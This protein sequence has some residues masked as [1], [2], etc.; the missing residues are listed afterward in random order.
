MKKKYL[1]LEYKKF[2]KIINIKLSR[3]DNIYFKKKFLQKNFKYRYLTTKE[4]D[5]F[6]NSYFLKLKNNNFTK[7]GKL[8]KKTWNK[9]WKENYSEYKKTKNKK[10]LIP[11]FVRS[12]LPIRIN[13]DFILPSSNSFE[14][15]LYTFCLEI[16]LKKYLKHPIKNLYEFGCGS[17]HN[18][19]K[20]KKLYPKLN[21]YGSDWSIW[22][23]KIINEINKNN[24]NYNIKSFKFDMFNPDTTL[25]IQNNSAVLTVGALEQLGKNFKKFIN[26]LIKKKTKIC[27]HFETINEFYNNSTM[28]DRLTL[29]YLKKRNYLE[30]FYTYLLYLEEKKIIK[31]LNKRRVF[32]SQYHEGYSLLVYKIL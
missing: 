11:K 22:S 15:D 6:L 27:L 9:G 17:C 13:G 31:I 12:K 5:L 8:K 21:L 4:F 3:L 7:S 26:F 24:I 1:N 25:K 10:K 28:S 14:T 29:E 18:L 2:I 16:V 30:N 32:G 19:I 23:T 20:I